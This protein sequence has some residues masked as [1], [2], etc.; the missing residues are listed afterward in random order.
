MS[1]LVDKGLKAKR[2]SKRVDFKSAFDPESTDEW[3]EL[4]KDIVAMANSRGGVIVIGLDNSGGP[5]KK[6]VKAILELDHAKLVDKV[7]KY[8]GFEFGELEI[9]EAKKH[10]EIV[11]VIEISAVKVPMVFQEV[12]T[13]EASPGKQ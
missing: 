8:T 10:S 9:H 5:S 13:Y 11:A 7:R 3:C 6:D 1:K 12:G 2:E 4:V